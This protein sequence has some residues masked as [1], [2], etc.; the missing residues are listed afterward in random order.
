MKPPCW[1]MKGV[2]SVNASQAVKKITKDQIKVIYTL[3]NELG[4]VDRMVSRD[5]LHE[6][7]ESM[8]GKSHISDLSSMQAN[9]VIT[10]LKSSMRGF[11]RHKKQTPKK[12]V[13]GMASA[14]QKSK[15]WR[16]MYELQSYD[17]VQYAASLNDR[18]RGFLKRYAGIDDMRFLSAEQA[19]RVIEG[20]KGAVE[21]AS[22]KVS[23]L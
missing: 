1:R 14:K 11:E 23:Y 15:I 16:L 10:R 4:I 7:I 20:L 6:M 17:T 22:S 8:T 21:S 19:W 5:S 18:L 13:P 9:S 12:D 3:G 2:F